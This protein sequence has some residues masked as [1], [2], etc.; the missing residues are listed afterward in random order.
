MADRGT[1]IDR[2]F[3][4]QRL[5]RKPHTTG[6]L[7]KALGCSRDTAERVLAALRRAGVEIHT[8]RKGREAWH[9][10]SVS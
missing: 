8:E 1:S 5:L 4:A 10:V 6:G 3:A 7:A 2:A 9:R